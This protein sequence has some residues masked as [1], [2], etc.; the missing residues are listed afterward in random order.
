MQTAGG[1]TDA[2][3]SGPASKLVVEILKRMAQVRR[4]RRK[5]RK[6]H[7]A[8]EDR[9]WQSD[10]S[11]RA[12]A[13]RLGQ[14]PVAESGPEFALIAEAAEQSEKIMG[15]LDGWNSTYREFSDVMAEVTP[16]TQTELSY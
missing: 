1:L 12:T 16:H 14:E 8:L 5:N 7:A 9:Y 13:S 2:D 4:L 11:T 6:H 15:M 10:A 3:P